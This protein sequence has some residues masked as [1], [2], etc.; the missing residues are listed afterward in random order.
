MSFV[1]LYE[2]QPGFGEIDVELRK[3]G[4]I[5]HHMLGVKT[6]IIS[7]L[8]LNNDPWHTL[9]QLVETDMIYVRDFRRM[10]LMDDE[11]LKHLCLVV[12]GCYGSF[13]LAYRC[14]LELEQRGS[15]AAGS[16]QAYLVIVNEAMAGG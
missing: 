2:G 1:P 8:L 11:Q 6:A 16:Q 5:P 14:V 4:F 10:D 13:D 9:N 12:H 15:L 7:P 3:L